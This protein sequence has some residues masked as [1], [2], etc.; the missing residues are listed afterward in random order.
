MET[1]IIVIHLMVIV[2]LIAVVLMQ[3]SEGGALGIGGGGNFM[4]TRGQTNVLTRTTAILA[5]AFFATSIALTLISRF[6]ENPASILNNVQSTPAPISTDGTAG[7]TA[8]AAAAPLAIRAQPARRTTVRGSSTNCR[9]SR[10]SPAPRRT[11]RPDRRSRPAT[12]LRRLRHRRPSKSGRQGR[13]SL[14]AGGA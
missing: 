1:V 12:S 11:P 9:R 3:R 13:P 6:E 7:G 4:S 5:A 10:R 2:A 14:L 8:G